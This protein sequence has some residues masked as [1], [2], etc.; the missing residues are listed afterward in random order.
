MPFDLEKRASVRSS[1]ATFSTKRTIRPPLRSTAISM[2]GE[3]VVSFADLAAGHEPRLQHILSL[4]HALLDA[5]MLSG[6]KHEHDKHQQQNQ[7]H[8]LGLV[9]G[10]LDFFIAHLGCGV[11]AAR[12]LMRLLVGNP[13]IMDTVVAS[14][15]LVV[16]GLIT[17]LDEHVSAALARKGEVMHADGV[18]DEEIAAVVDVLSGLCYISEFG[19]I[20]ENQDYIAG[21]LLKEGE[22]SKILV[23]T[24]VAWE[25]HSS[26]VTEGDGDANRVL[27]SGHNVTQLMMP[28]GLWLSLEKFVAEETKQATMVLESILGLLEA[29]CLGKNLKSIELVR[30]SW[31]G[32]DVCLS[33][34]M[35]VKLPMDLRAKFCDLLT[36]R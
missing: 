19:P 33:S 24:R 11:G 15:E 22:A 29:L 28:Q 10:S 30:Q 27:L 6:G 31:I 35:D 12:T 5:F 1:L 16:G 32:Q 14:R 36:G 21:R 17:F 4:C 13:T 20:T 2:D 3:E 9:G 8:V 7:R 23:H 25:R 26:V 18:N 34:L